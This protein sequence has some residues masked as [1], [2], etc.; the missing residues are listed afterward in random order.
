MP[1]IHAKTDSFSMVAVTLEILPS[2]PALTFSLCNE[3]ELLTAEAVHCLHLC[4]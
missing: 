2:F 1:P 3:T 4:D